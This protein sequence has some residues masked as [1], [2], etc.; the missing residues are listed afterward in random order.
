M[1]WEINDCGQRMYKNFLWS[2]N[3]PNLDKARATQNSRS[4]RKWNSDQSKRPTNKQTKTHC[5][6]KVL[7]KQ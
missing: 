7:S 6:S 4:E 3:A 1:I 2:R 5:N